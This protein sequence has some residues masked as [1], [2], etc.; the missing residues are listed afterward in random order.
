MVHVGETDVVVAARL[1]ALW[2]PIRREP[3]GDVQFFDL[4]DEGQIKGIGRF[5]VT[6]LAQAVVDQHRHLLGLANGLLDRFVVFGNPGAVHPALGEYN[7]AMWA[8]KLV[9]DLAGF[10]VHC[11]FPENNLLRAFRADEHIRPDSVV[12]CAKCDPR[13]TRS[14]TKNYFTDFLFVFLRGCE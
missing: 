10:F 11:R 13:R 3:V 6:L 5:L 14:F 12:D 9:V 1:V 7:P 2:H 8:G 4:L